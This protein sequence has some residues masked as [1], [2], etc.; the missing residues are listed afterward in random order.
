[1]MLENVERTCADHPNRYDCGD[2]L[3]DYWPSSR[4]YGLIVHD[5]GSSVVII[6]YCPWCGTKLPERLQ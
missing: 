2:C 4:T 6:D 3:V 1:M 5:V